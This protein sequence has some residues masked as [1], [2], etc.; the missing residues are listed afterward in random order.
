[1]GLLPEEATAA[2]GG[3]LHLPAL[4]LSRSELQDVRWVAK[5]ALPPALQGECRVRAA[6]CTVMYREW[7]GLVPHSAPRLKRATVYLAC[8]ACPECVNLQII[9]FLRDLQFLQISEEPTGLVYGL[10]PLERDWL[11]MTLP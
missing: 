10:P 9:K 6:H 1:M 3:Q 2:A 7:Y 5:H 4:D 11:Q 8:C